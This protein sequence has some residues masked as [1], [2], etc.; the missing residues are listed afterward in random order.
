MDGDGE[1]DYFRPRVSP[2]L[3]ARI[4]R[5]SVSLCLRG[6]SRCPDALPATATAAAVA[7]ATTTAAAVA[8]G[9][10]AAPGVQ[11]GARLCLADVEGASADFLP[12]HGG[13]R[14]LRLLGRDVH[15]AK[16]LW[17]ARL[18]HRDRGA[19]GAP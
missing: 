7:A 18:V 9:R 11:L 6:E 13:D 16:P 5:I 14:L 19:G 10:A 12:L 17:A 15:V 8:A 3:R 4:R 2:F 1:T